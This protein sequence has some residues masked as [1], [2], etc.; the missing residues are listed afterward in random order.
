MMQSAISQGVSIGI[1]L[2]RHRITTFFTDDGKGKQ[3]A[4]HRTFSTQSSPMPKFNAFIGAKYSFHTLGKDFIWPWIQC[5]KYKSSCP[6]NT[7]YGRYKQYYY[8]YSGRNIKPV[9]PERWKYKGSICHEYSKRKIGTSKKRINK[10]VRVTPNFVKQL[11]PNKNNEL[12]RTLFFGSMV[13]RKERI[14][15]RKMSIYFCRMAVCK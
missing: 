14:N 2:V 6:M 7:V 15:E 9:L 5:T 11:W 8:K 10:R 3:M 1:L 4:R 13:V 12:I